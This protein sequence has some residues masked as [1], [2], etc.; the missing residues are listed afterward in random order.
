VYLRQLDVPLPTME[1]RRTSRT[2]AREWGGGS[3]TDRSRRDVL[4]DQDP[5]GDIEDRPRIGLRTVDINHQDP[6]VARWGGGLWNRVD[7]IDTEEDTDAFVANLTPVSRGR[8]AMAEVH[9][10]GEV[11][12]QGWLDYKIW[13]ALASFNPAA[14]HEWLERG[15]DPNSISPL[16]GVATDVSLLMASVARG[17]IDTVSNL[18]EYNANVA[19]RDW[20]GRTALHM[21]VEQDNIASV[22]MLRWRRA[23][24]LHQGSDGQTPLDIAVKAGRYMTVVA[25]LHNFT[26]PIVRNG[27]RSTL[28]HYSAEHGTAQIAIKLIDAGVDVD[29]R[30]MNHR[31]PL[32]LAVCNGHEL[33]VQK[34]LIAG[35]HTLR[36]DRNGKTPIDMAAERDNPRILDD[37]NQAMRVRQHSRQDP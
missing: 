28:L 10:H 8:L 12:S 7:G 2:G 17:D 14:V 16:E 35:A 13:L 19:H 37:L 15:A 1:Y 31:T 22:N 23:N 32:H 26:G 30:D 3:I 34:L 18:L 29:V 4:P 9:G 36:L 20:R 33:T 21:A 5:G 11:G 27:E 25:L 6:E 24:P